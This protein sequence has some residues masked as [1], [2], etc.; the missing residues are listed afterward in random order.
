MSAGEGPNPLDLLKT[1]YDPLTHAVL[2]LDGGRDNGILFLAEFVAQLDN[3][4]RTILGLTI[5]LAITE[6]IKRAG[7]YYRQ[8]G[9]EDANSVDNLVGTLFLLDT[10]G[11]PGLTD[12]PYYWA[13]THGWCWN[14]ENPEQWSFRFWYWRMIGI[15][16][17]VKAVAGQPLGYQDQI[18]WALGTFVNALS[19]YGNT[20]DKCQQLLHNRIMEKRQLAIPNAAITLWRWIMSRKYPGGA[21]EL[22]TIYFGQNHP[23]TQLARKDFL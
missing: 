10:Y 22:Y 17:L 19:A 12:Q 15:P 8:P 7:L 11:F 9:V 16:P 2:A 18:L 5:Q 6:R 4:Q 23:I 3:S 13:T 20:S 1:Y 21:Q 14:V